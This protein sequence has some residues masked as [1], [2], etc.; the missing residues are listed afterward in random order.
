M[1][2]S[3]T[4]KYVII[5][6]DGEC[7]FCNKWV[8]WTLRNKPNKNIKF[9]A[10]Q[11]DT[12]RNILSQYNIAFDLNSIIVVHKNKSYEKSKAISVILDNINSRRK[13]LKYL[14]AIS[15]NWLSDFCYNLIARN[16]HK[17]SGGADSCELPSAEEKKFFSLNH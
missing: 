10:L 1:I 8:M 5:L 13:Y 6:Y 11:S 15:P 9:I 14:L 12:G 7:G 17:I 4:D 2:E 16:R 3:M